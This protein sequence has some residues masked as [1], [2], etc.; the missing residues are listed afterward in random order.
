[1]TDLKQRLID[2]TDL[3]VKCGLCLPHCPTYVVEKNENESPR[4]RINMISALAQ[5][6]LNPSSTIEQQ[7]DHC[8]VCRACENMCPAHVPYHQ[9]F[10]GYQQAFHPQKPSKI[11]S[12]LSQQ[13]TLINRTL[14]VL[15][16]LRFD[17]LIRHPWFD[18]LPKH[19]AENTFEPR[20]T[21]ISTPSK[22]TVG[23]FLGCASQS[24][25]AQTLKDSIFVLRKIGFDIFIPDKQQCC[26]AMA[27][28]RG[29]NAKTEQFVKTNQKVFSHGSL[30][31]IVSVASGCGATLKENLHGDTPVLDIFDV[32]SPHLN[33][34][35]FNPKNA[36][37]MLHTPCSLKN[38]LSKGSNIKKE[39]RRIPQLN[40]ID[41][42]DISC[43]G[44]SGTH[45]LKNTEHA[46][47]FREPIIQALIEQ[48]CDYFLTSNIGCAMHVR[49][50]IKNAGLHTTVLHPVS[51]LAQQLQ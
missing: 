27:L 24:F 22:G 5:E 8:L 37:V 6:K 46:N 45:M 18:Y 42:P 20:Y 11:E 31:S 29:D 33:T 2:Q 44:A 40:I 21:A 1:M 26:G 3:C 34:Q 36:S 50:G 43:C 17:R 30:H 48:P 47:R 39:L 16:T 32:I 41:T 14:R 19:I 35:T 7:L 9:L 25:D 49:A 15:K 51:L 13:A 10:T 12:L 23:L 38:A 28:H 4:G